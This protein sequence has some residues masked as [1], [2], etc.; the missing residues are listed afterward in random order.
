MA[1][2]REK[3][4]IHYSGMDTDYCWASEIDSRF[5]GCDMDPNRPN[6]PKVDTHRPTYTLP[7]GPRKWLDAKSKE[8]GVPIPDDLEWWVS[9]D[10]MPREKQKFKI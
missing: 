6:E 8:L 3:P 1:R 5:N 9:V 4:P 7:L 2:S 10:G